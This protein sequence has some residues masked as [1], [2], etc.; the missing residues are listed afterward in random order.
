M[1]FK[2]NKLGSGE[3][4]E[5]EKE[6]KGR[7]VMLTFWT[8]WCPDSYK[9]L[10]A[11]R[12][13]YQTMDQDQLC[14]VTINVTGREGEVDLQEWLKQHNHHFLVLK[15]DGT[16]VYDQ[17]GCEGVPTTV[18]LNKELLVVNRFGENASIA[19][20]MASLTTIV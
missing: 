8:S 11:K 18:L 9:D 7:P 15:D 4:W 17:F 16:T 5:L 2:L 12:A 10:A 6:A 3:R 14:F 20:I 13:L 1:N 19:S